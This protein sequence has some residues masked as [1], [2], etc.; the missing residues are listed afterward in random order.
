[1]LV[2]TSHLQ[3]LITL[4][5]SGGTLCDVH[6]RVRKD[7]SQKLSTPLRCLL[8]LHRHARPRLTLLQTLLSTQLES[9]QVRYVDN[10]AVTCLVRVRHHAASSQPSASREHYYA[11]GHL[12]LRLLAAA[13]RAPTSSSAGARRW[14]DDLPSTV[15][16]A[17]VV[18]AVLGWLESCT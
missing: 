12:G 6:S 11:L 13:D 9:R 4:S 15:W 14:L 5:L 1:M 17:P 18:L 16:C 7:L 8:I 3:R 10:V 2:F